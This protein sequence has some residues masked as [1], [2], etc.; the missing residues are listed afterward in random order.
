MS[1]ADDDPALPMLRFV[2]V[3]ALVPHEDH[4]EQRMAPLVRR[5]REQG[6][7]RNPPIVAPLPDAG[8]AHPLWVVLDGANR[9]SAARAAGLAHIVVQIV[10][11]EDPE[12]LLTTWS[13]AFTELDRD[14]FEQRCAALP[15]LTLRHE[16]LLRARAALARRELLAYI[17]WADQCVTVLQGGGSLPERNRLLHA[18]VGLYRG[19]RYF[20]APNDAL[21]R[22]RAR[23]PE[24]TGLIVFPHFEP[25]E[26][27]E[28]AT[29]GE[30]L[31]AGITRHLIRWRALRVNVPIAVLADSETTLEQKNRWLDEWLA[32]LLAG[33]HVRYYAE[34][35]VVFDE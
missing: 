29:A 26:V 11:Y 18:I 21:E 28:L 33:R 24:V 23:H 27:L 25:A 31:P 15:G 34:P 12:V 19:A 32:D 8:P 13:H 14:T 35:T 22:V 5:L 20:R 16:P 2:P 17:A 10:P 6:M 1:V 9:A 4:D 7:L 3:D 30:R